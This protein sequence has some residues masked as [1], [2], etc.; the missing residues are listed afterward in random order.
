MAGKKKS[1]EELEQDVLDYVLD[2]YNASKRDRAT[3]ETKWQRYDALYNK[4]PEFSDR[5]KGRNKK[6]DGMRSHP[7]DSP[8]RLPD[9]L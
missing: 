1:K 2:F 6:D 7:P 8:A 3:L 4:E 9:F 5:K